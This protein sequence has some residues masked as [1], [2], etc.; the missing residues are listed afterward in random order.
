MHDGVFAPSHPVRGLPDP[1]RPAELAS[2][3]ADRLLDDLAITPLRPLRV[4]GE[5][6]ALSWARSGLMALTGTADGSPQMCPAP[7]AACADGALA[8]LASLAP[9]PRML[10]ELRGSSLLVERAALTGLSRQGAIS[11]GG[12]CR[13]IAAADGLLAVNLA[14]PDDWALL[15]AWLEAP[16]ESWA[17]VIAALALQPSAILVERARWLGLAVARSETPRE[18]RPWF[19]RIAEGPRRPADLRRPPRVLDL[20][21][22][23]AGPLCGRLLHQLGCE[24]VKL[25][26]LARPDGARQGQAAFFDAMNAGKASVVLDFGTPA[27][28]A[29]LAALMD[30]ADIV[31]EASRPRALRQ[32][33]IDAEARI[34][35]RPGLTWISLTGYG[36]R[37]PQDQWI[38]YGDDAGVAGG[39]SELL[40]ITTGQPLFCADAIGDPLSG[41]HAAL[42]A[43]ATHLQGGGRLLSVAL[44]D[45]VA[46]VAAFDR[47]ATGA[48]LRQRAQ[49][50]QQRAAGEVRMPFARRPMQPARTL[51][52]DTASVLKAWD[53]PC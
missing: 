46:Q 3:Y 29:Q 45:V 17:D 4:V 35:A 7:L 51:G 53:V 38:A 2:A 24:V 9:E 32:L 49:D 28:R 18:P 16:A 43:W 21:S 47:P 42:A 11:P 10:A 41:L 1:A 22:L 19:E 13:L 48:L 44:R 36:R 37:T 12:S 34:R 39:L 23:W 14:R 5:H 15:P 33:G 6:P 30:R 8:A 20:S 40:R 52:A 31:I 27:G 50:W 26:S 25:E